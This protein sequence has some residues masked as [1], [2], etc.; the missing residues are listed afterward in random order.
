MAMDPG[1]Q[2]VLDL[3]RELGRP[4]LE[5]ST[6]AE[7]RENMARGREVFGPDPVEVAEIRTLAATGPAGGIPLRY[8]RGI[9]APAN[10]APALVYFHGG[11][12][13]LGDLDSHARVCRRLAD[14]ARGG[15]VSVRYGL[16]PENRFP[17]SVDDSA[18]A[19]RWV[20]E[21]AAALGIDPARV[22]VGGDSAGG[23]LAAVMALMARDGALPKLCFQLLIYPA[24]D[25]AATYP[26][27]ERTMSGLLL[28]APGMRWF[29]GL[30]L[31]DKQEG[32]DWRAS[33]LRATSLAGTAPALVFTAYHDPLCDEGEAYAARLERDGVRVN[34]VRFGD[35]I[36]GF[37]TMGRFIPAADT[38]LDMAAAALRGAWAG[39]AAPA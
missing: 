21:Q 16:A 28:T 35:Q 24:T 27:Y 11:G 17:A 38:M 2:R 32:Y 14:D 7:A 5:Q 13:V 34:R 36:H 15:G 9:G 31:N 19:T 29:I 8:Y 20:V 30:Y 3:L 23:N 22:A 37:L 39:E 25:M 33:P 4:P 6:V 12:W 10:G 26:S 18:A 1:A